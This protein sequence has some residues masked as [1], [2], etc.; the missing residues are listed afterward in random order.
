MMHTPFTAVVTHVLSTLIPASSGG[1]LEGVSEWVANLMNTLGA[2]GVGLALLLENLFPP[3]PSEAILPLAGFTASHPDATFTVYEAIAWA[4]AGAVA[5]AIVLYWIGRLL[6]HDRMVSI[7]RRVPLVSEDDVTKT[8][9][10]FQRH[11][12]KAVFFG[13]M[14]PIFRSLISIPA[15]IEKMAVPKFLLLTTLGSLIWN[16]VFISLGFWLGER[17]QT[18]LDY[19]GVFEKVVL[20]ILIGLIVWWLIAKI[21][22]RKLERE[23]GEW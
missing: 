13:R 21:R 8:V 5:G 4:T 1:L 9:A 7:A 10:F 19:S 12:G 22:K 15:G 17:W 23:A 6:G 2:P 14:L 18:V 11:G 3:I 20:V 16:T